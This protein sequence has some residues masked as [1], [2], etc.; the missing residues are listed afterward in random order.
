MAE[1]LYQLVES[2]LE[3]LTHKRFVVLEILGVFTVFGQ[4]IVKFT[5]K[6]SEFFLPKFCVRSEQGDMIRLSRCTRL[7]V[8]SKNR[9]VVCCCPFDDLLHLYQN[10]IFV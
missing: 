9:I 8:S 7:L 4:G 5:S 3:C 10:L 1:A 2:L 6:I